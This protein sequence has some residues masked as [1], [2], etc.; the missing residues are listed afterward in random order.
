MN[1]R[2]GRPSTSNP[3]ANRRGNINLT[4]AL[5]AHLYERCKWLA[6]YYTRRDLAAEP[7]PVQVWSTGKVVTTAV[8]KMMQDIAHDPEIAAY[9]ELMESRGQGKTGPDPIED[10]L[11]LFGKS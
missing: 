7:G 4:V 8:S 3:H 6:A 1:S 11:K 5:P 10:V 9:F 2:P